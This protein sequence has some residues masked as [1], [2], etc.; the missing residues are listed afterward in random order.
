MHLNGSNVAFAGKNHTLS[1]LEY[2][3][4]DEYHDIPP[5]IEVSRGCGAG[6]YFCVEGNIPLHPLKSPNNIHE[7]IR[8]YSSL[9]AQEDSHF[10]F[11]ASNFRPSELWMS[12]FEYMYFQER[13]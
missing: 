2:S 8:N 5:S 12:E 4:L 10:Y 1:C 3:I 6:C 9:I 13:P 7:E 11:E